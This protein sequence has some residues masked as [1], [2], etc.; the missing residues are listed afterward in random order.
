MSEDPYKV[1]GVPKTAT[2]DEIKKAYRKLA[3]SLHPDLHPDDPGLAVQLEED[4]CLAFRI[5]LGNSLTTDLQRKNM[6]QLLK[7]FLASHKNRQHG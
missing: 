2:Q 1:L 6:R 5:G 4:L 7:H 3:K